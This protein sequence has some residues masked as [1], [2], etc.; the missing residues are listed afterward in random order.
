M[1]P[2]KYSH[3]SYTCPEKFIRDSV[4]GVAP[5]LLLFVVTVTRAYA[6]W[7]DGL[8]QHP[9]SS[10]QH[11]VTPQPRSN[12]VKHPF[13]NTDNDCHQW[14]SGSFRVHQIRFRSGFFHGLRWGC[15]QRSPRP[16]SCFKGAILLRGRMIREGREWDRV[17]RG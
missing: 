14:L 15:L 5:F 2:T 4:I 8:S 11:P 1:R 16:P 17:G 7:G 13:Q 3:M 12:F 10:Q 6:E 9:L